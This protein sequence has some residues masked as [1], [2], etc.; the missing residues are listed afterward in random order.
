MGVPYIGRADHRATVAAAFAEPG[1]IVLVCGE[2]GVGKSSLV[3]AER[4]GAVTEVI[5][6]ACLQLA[7][8]PLPL[9]ALEQI[10]DARGGWPGNPDD[11][12]Q[13]AEERLRAIR[14]W[15]DA[16]VSNRSPPGPGNLALDCSST[17]CPITWASPEMEIAGGATC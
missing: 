1:H 13:S 14:R 15:A 8:Q 5:E 10:F 3:A 6:G 16:L 7:G 17:L 11:A 4:V 12:E 2:A 9:A